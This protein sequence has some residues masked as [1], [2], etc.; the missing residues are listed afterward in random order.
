MNGMA[1]C[2]RTNSKVRTLER[3]VSSRGRDAQ[4]IQDHIRQVLRHDWNPLGGL[5]GEVYADEYDGYIGGIYRLLARNASA[6]EIAAHLARLEVDAMGMPSLDPAR[7]VPVAEKLMQLDL[8][9]R[10]R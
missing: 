2:R 8:P 5:G 3:A 4:R 6:R 7:L 9:A 1:L 10:G